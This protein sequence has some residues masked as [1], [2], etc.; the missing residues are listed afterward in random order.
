VS[1][2]SLPVAF[3]YAA[4]GVWRALRRE[5]NF[6]IELGIGVL[7]LVL[8]WWLGAPLVP[9]LLAAGL[10]LSAELVNSAIESVVDLAS[11]DQNELAAAAKDMAAGGVLVAST[12]AL[13]VG[14]AV[15]GPPLLVRM[16]V[17]H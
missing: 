17:L 1:R 14:L 10:V 8:A 11:P 2:S 13:L 3:G 7:A 4:R 9:V 15:L 16:G 6:R 5:A 12:F